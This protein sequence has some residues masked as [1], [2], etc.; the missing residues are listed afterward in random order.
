MASVLLTVTATVSVTV[1]LPA[2]FLVCLSSSA[3]ASIASGVTV[4]SSIELILVS[5][6]NDVGFVPAVVSTP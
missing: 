1:S 2:M 3:E 6:L 4:I 5:N